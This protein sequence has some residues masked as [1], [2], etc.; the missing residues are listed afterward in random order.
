M[1]TPDERTRSVVD[2]REFL[3]LLARGG[4]ITI[5]GLVQSVA[6]GLLRH[7]PQ[8]IDIDVSAVV[9]PSVW[10]RPEQQ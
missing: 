10:A 7:Y 2:T 6:V 9:L 8:H 1:T 3:E 5:S 4:E